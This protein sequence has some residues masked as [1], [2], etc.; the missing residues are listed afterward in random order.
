M[1]LEEFFS[2]TKPFKKIN[3]I[4][5]LLNLAGNDVIYSVLNVENFFWNFSTEI[6]IFKFTNVH[7]HLWY[8]CHGISEWNVL[9]ETIHRTFDTKRRAAAYWDPPLIVIDSS[10]PRWCVKCSRPDERCT[11]GRDAWRRS[12]T[13][14]SG[15]EWGGAS[16]R[17]F[18]GSHSGPGGLQCSAGGRD[19]RT[20][21]DRRKRAPEPQMPTNAKPEAGKSS[22]STWAGTL[23]HDAETPHGP[24]GGHVF[25]LRHF[26]ALDLRRRWSDRWVFP[27]LFTASTFRP[28]LL[29]RV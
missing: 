19:A 12:G 25:L 18:G 24:A 20:S 21:V 29:G 27:Q 2:R 9:M 8:V 14:T 28:A 16:D 6:K 13:S 26:P 17:K 10:R 23:R 5:Q 4:C 1:T 22:V 3:K 15:P 11:K 7:I